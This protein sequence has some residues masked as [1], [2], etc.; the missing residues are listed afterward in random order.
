MK[1]DQLLVRFRRCERGNVLITFALSITILIAAAGLGAEVASW[2]SSRRDMQNAADLGAA[3]GV[4]SLAYNFPGSATFD[5]YAAKEAK[6][7][8]SIHGFEDGSNN[9]TVTVNIPPATGPY[10]STTYNHKAIE[11]IVARP[12]TAL[13][14]GLFLS[15]GP[16]ITTRSVALLDTSSGACLLVLNPNTAK[17]LSFQGSNT[18]NVPCGTEVAS[19]SN[20]SIDVT[21]AAATIN[22]GTLETAGQIQDPHNDIT[23]TSTTTGATDISNVYN[24]R[25]LPTLASGYPHGSTYPADKLSTFTPTQSYTGDI[26]ASSDLSS[27]FPLGCA[28]GCVIHGNI[29]ASG[30]TV[31]LGSGVYFVDSGGNTSNGNVTI[32]ANGNITTNGGTIVLTSSTGTNV[33]TFNMQS[34]TATVTMLAPSSTNPTDPGYSVTQN[35]PGLAGIAMMQDPLATESTVKKN[36][37]CNS[38]CSTFQGGPSSSFNGALYFPQGN[39]TYQGTPTST[40]CFQLI[41]DTLTVAGDPNISVT[42]C[43]QGETLFGPLV[44]KLV[45]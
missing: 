13:F 36:G 39:V 5:T 30:G 45:E 38:N 14:S 6:G 16:T 31:N 33:G 1:A 8:T 32:G 28:A 7:A 25:S 35:F 34:A 15:S 42:G 17:A 19:N 29:N 44:E 22:L 26:T 12:V 2:Y 4:K 23:A 20:D 9:T 41:V 18:I 43:T 37:N 3:S 11:V 10:A 21:G 40:T 27:I 24:T